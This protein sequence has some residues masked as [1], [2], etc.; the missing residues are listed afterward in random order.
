MSQSAEPTPLTPEEA[1]VQRWLKIIVVALG[2]LILVML[3][4]IVSTVLGK[5]DKKEDAQTPQVVTETATAPWSSAPVAAPGAPFALD[6]DIPAQAMVADSQV[7]GN[8]LILRLSLPR[9]GEEIIIL[10]IVS[11]AERGRVRLKPGS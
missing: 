9:G 4:I 3:G 2:A 10:D 6:V 1:R 11:G 8:L 7:D 5:A